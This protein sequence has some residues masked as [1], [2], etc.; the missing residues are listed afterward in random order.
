MRG[1]QGKFTPNNERDSIYK[2]SM[3]WIGGNIRFTD[4]CRWT[5]NTPDAVALLEV[6]GPTSRPFVELKLVEFWETEKGRQMERVISV[7]IN[8]E[9]VI[10]LRDML[11]RLIEGSQ[12]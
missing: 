9:N 3:G 8:E 11:N 6:Y 2:P 10:S 5:Q 7:T 12:R 4:H 1:D